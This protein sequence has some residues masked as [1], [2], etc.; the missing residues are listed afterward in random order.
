M[1]DWSEDAPIVDVPCPFGHD[2]VRR[3]LVDTIWQAEGSAEYQCSECGVV[4]L[5]PIM[6]PE[7]ERAFYEGQFAEYMAKRGQAGG[8]DPR[9][10]FE[11]WQPEGARRLELL[12][13]WLREGMRVLEIGAAT[14]FLLE[15]IRPYVGE[16]VGIEPGDDFR[17]F[18]ID[19]LGIEAYPTRDAVEG[20]EFDLIL[21]YYVVEHLRDPVAELNEW[22]QF[23]APG[24]HLA[25]EVPNVDDALVKYWQVE[26]FDRFYWQKAHYFNYSHQTLDMVLRMA[27]FADVETVPVQRYDLSNHVH[28]LWKGEPG[29]AGKYADLLDEGVNAEYARSLRERWLCDTV[30]AVAT[31][32]G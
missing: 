12:R 30:M 22:R 15:A 2:G 3:R 1:A 31:N 23:L 27:G 25:I 14:G 21:S 17:Q 16:V 20:R 4:F 19:E 10:S 9:S 6:T 28:W 18:S 7:E 8:A 13:P 5:H 11:K 29:G 26:A 32:A 24:G